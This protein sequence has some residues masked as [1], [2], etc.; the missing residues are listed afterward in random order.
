MYPKNPPRRGYNQPMNQ[1]ILRE[2]RRLA[3]DVFRPNAEIADQ[4]TIDGQVGANVRALAD[5]GYFGLGIPAQYGGMGAD[6]ATRREY[7][8]LM[9]SACG[10]TAFMLPSLDVVAVSQAPS[11]GSS[12]N[13]P[14]PVATMFGQYPNIES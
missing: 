10:V 2:A 14:L 6:D 1:D 13:P 12:P 9:A 7:T 5:A 3:D 8:E 11:P 4:G